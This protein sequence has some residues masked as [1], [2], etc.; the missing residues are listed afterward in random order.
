MANISYEQFREG[1]INALNNAAYER[2]LEL[3][4]NPGIQTKPNEMIDTL[5]IRFGESPICPSVSLRKEYESFLESGKDIWDYG[6]EEL[7]RIY[8]AFENFPSL[9]FKPEDV[10]YDYVRENVF[11][12]LMNKSMNSEMCRT[13]PTLSFCD[14]LVQV[15]YVMVSRNKDGISAFRLTYDLSKSIKMTDDEVIKFA[16]INSQQEDYECHDMGEILPLPF[17]NKEQIHVLTSHDNS[18]GAIAMTSSKA[19]EKAT[20]RMGTDQFFIIPS[21]IHE[22]LLVPQKNVEDPAELKKIC[23]EIN[24]NREVIAK[25]EVLSNTI[26]RYNGKIVQECNS[27][28][29]LKRQMD[30]EKENETETTSMIRRMK[31]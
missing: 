29:E 1:F 27:L 2:R 9:G 4:V 8:E 3:E 5:T 25:S 6:E 28:S 15:P 18:W 17:P 24:S 11:F 31:Q 14:N 10:T 23:V 30:Q 13:S 21:S 22:L 12:R 20:E 16:R 26:Y 19:L 7:S